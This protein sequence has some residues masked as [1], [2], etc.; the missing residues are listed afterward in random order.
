MFYKIHIRIPAYSFLI[1]LL[2]F[3]TFS[4]K[5]SEKKVKAP[6]EVESPEE[7]ILASPFFSAETGSEVFRVYIS[8]D[9]YLTKQYRFQDL[10]ERKADPGGDQFIREYLKEFDKIDEERIGEIR[11]MLYPHTGTINKIQP[12]RLTFL[13]ELDRLMIDDI[14]RWVF[15]FPKERVWPTDFLI[16]YKF[17]LQ[18]KLTKEKTLQE[19]ED[20][21]LKKNP[22]FYQH[23]MRKKREMGNQ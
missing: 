2:T 11:V 14:Q 10:I 17:Q 8:S 6:V 16:R 12:E 4:C 1:I 15:Q 20:E 3:F 19:L 13:T 21:Y 23:L 5:T 9:Y 22:E 7:K 18:S